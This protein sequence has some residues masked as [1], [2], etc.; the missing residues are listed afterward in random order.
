MAY[1][2]SELRL[3]TPSFTGNLGGPQIWA[4]NGTDA[5]TGG[6]RLANYISDAQAR[7]MRKGDIVYYYQWDSLTTRATLS[8]VQIAVVLSVASTGADLSDGQAIAVANTNT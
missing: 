6:A 3:L 7:G 4:L 5:F 2:P 1:T 8:L